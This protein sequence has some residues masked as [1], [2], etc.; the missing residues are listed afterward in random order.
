MSRQPAGS[1]STPARSLYD[2]RRGFNLFNMYDVND[3]FSPFPDELLVIGRKLGFDLVRLCVDYRGWASP[4]HPNTYDTAR[5]RHIR[6]TVN[7]AVDLGFIVVLDMHTAPG[8]NADTESPPLRTSVSSQRRFTRL[9]QHLA[10]WLKD[11]PVPSL[12]FN[13]LNEPEDHWTEAQLR[14]VIT[15]AAQAVRQVTPDRRMVVDGM[16]WGRTPAP[17]LAAL[18]I[19]QS[20][21]VYDP[22]PL[23]HWRA[24]F[25]PG[26]MDWPQPD[27]P[28]HVDRQ[29]SAAWA[30]SWDQDRVERQLLAP[31]R[32]L[33]PESQV[34]VGEFGVYKHTPHRVTLS[35]LDDVCELF[36]RSRWGWAL[37]HLSGPFGVLD[38]RRSDV[39]YEAYHGHQLDRQ[40]LDVLLRPRTQA[41]G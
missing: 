23:T 40:M 41:R 2:S 25:Q 14:R 26:A 7:R 1:S 30:G 34:F 17:S 33:S 37:W 38:S 24:E 18:H 39:R 13:L 6:D 31:W 29:V 21:H 8:H 15:P 11:T 10:G 16:S 12:V 5:L 32:A 9:W 35:W 20:V 19:D 4:T 36:A 28:L 3:R 22:M 27:W